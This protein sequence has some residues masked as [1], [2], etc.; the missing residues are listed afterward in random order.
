MRGDRHP[1]GVDSHERPS[2]RSVAPQGGWLDAISS[3]VAGG[4]CGDDTTGAAHDIDEFMR[5]LARHNRRGQSRNVS[6]CLSWSA[7]SSRRS[8]LRS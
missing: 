1:R 6:G 5:P 2:V 7:C 8:E 3:S 4:I